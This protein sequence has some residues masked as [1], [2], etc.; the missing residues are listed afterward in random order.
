V[1]VAGLGPVS[2]LPGHGRAA[3]RGN[4]G[5]RDGYAPLRDYG[6]IGDGRTVALVARDGA[7]DWLCLPDLDSPSV[8]A[9]MLDAVDGSCFRLAPG[10]PFEV[11]RRYQPDTNILETTFVT[12]Q[13]TVRVTDAML[14]PRSGLAPARELARRVDCLSGRVRMQW[15]IEPRFDYGRR[16]GTIGNRAGVPVAT[17]GSLALAL[18]SWDAGAPRVRVRLDRGRGRALRRPELA[19]RTRG[20]PSGASGVPHTAG[21]RGAARSNASV[22]AVLGPGP[23]L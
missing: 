7:I 8:F 21:G 15:A 3:G 14:L 13:G 10:E 9:A 16:Q 20:R 4:A 23:R 18:R 22:L 17:S 19:A 12:G 6:V 1:D 5:R 2:A 11:E